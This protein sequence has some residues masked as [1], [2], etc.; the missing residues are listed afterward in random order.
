MIRSG[1]V[2]D[3]PVRIERKQTNCRSKSSARVSGE[4]RQVGQVVTRV[5]THSLSNQ[6]SRFLLACGY[7]PWEVTVKKFT[8]WFS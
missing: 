2:S 6:T 8:F 1:H 7:K 3:Y 5:A 4:K